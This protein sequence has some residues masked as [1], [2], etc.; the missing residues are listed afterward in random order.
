MGRGRKESQ[1][2]APAVRPR[3]SAPAALIR[4][5]E[6]PAP[7]GASKD[8]EKLADAAYRTLLGKILNREL[9]GGSVIQERKLALSMGVSRTPMRDA[10]GRLEGLG[11]L[12]RLTDRLLAVRVI[13]L[14]DY[15]HSLDV[16]ALIEPH[17]AALAAKSISSAELAH[18][19]H[20]LE[21]LAEHAGDRLDELHWR[22]DDLLHGTIAER[23]GN[24]ILRETIEAMRRY[25]K[26]FERQTVPLHG[27][28]GIEDHRRIL[29]ALAS[30]RPE[31]G[32]DAMADHIRQVRR[33]ALD[34]L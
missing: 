8:P 3:S 4:S 17:A 24:P 27:R 25:T 11:L 20:E 28:P 29:D 23:S 5:A 31:K 18:L 15:L 34:G 30:G 14:Q 6:A 2:A 10:V 16:R 21:A 7:H 19:R 13:T 1:P 22:F 26:I 32:R 12:V 9:P 33:R